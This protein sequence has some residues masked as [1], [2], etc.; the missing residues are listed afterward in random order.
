IFIQRLEEALKLYLPH[1]PP[2]GK[3][4]IIWI[5]PETEL[6][7]IANVG[8]CRLLSD[9]P[10][11]D[12]IR[13]YPTIIKSDEELA[14][15]FNS[16]PEQ[17]RGLIISAAFDE[18]SHLSG[19]IAEQ[20]LNQTE[21]DENT[22]AM[23]AENLQLLESNLAIVDAKNQNGVYP[24]GNWITQLHTIA[25][26]L[27]E[28][29]VER[30]NI[31]D[32]FIRQRGDTAEQLLTRHED[33]NFAL[34]IV[35]QE[36]KGFEGLLFDKISAIFSNLGIGVRLIGR[37][38]DSLLDKDALM[39]DIITQIRD[40][41]M[42]TKKQEPGSDADCK[43][44]LN[45]DHVSFNRA[46]E[47]IGSSDEHVAG[48]GIKLMQRLAKESPKELVYCLQKKLSII[49][50]VDAESR[51]RL[52]AHD[53]RTRE[54]AVELL[55]DLLNVRSN[56]L[57]ASLSIQEQV[58][59]LAGL[60]ASADIRKIS[61]IKSIVINI[62]K[63]CDILGEA[64]AS[65]IY[66]TKS[67]SVAGVFHVS[68]NKTNTTLWDLR[69]NRN[70]WVGA[71]GPQVSAE[72]ADEEREFREF[73]GK[74]LDG[75]TLRHTRIEERFAKNTILEFALSADSFS[76][77]LMRYAGNVISREDAIEYLVLAKRIELIFAAITQEIYGKLKERGIHYEFDYL[78]LY[79]D[80]GIEEAFGVVREFNRTKCEMELTMTVNLF[81]VKASPGMIAPCFFKAIIARAIGQLVFDSPCPQEL[82]DLNQATVLLSSQR[83]IDFNQYIDGLHFDFNNSVFTPLQC[84]A[85]IEAVADWFVYRIISPEE[86]QAFTEDVLSSSFAFFDSIQ[87]QNPWLNVNK[88]TLARFVAVAEFSGIRKSSSLLRVEWMLDKEARLFADKLKDFLKGLRFKSENAGQT[89]ADD[90][91]LSH[92]LAE[93]C[94]IKEMAD[95]LE[96]DVDYIARK[97]VEGG[98][99]LGDLDGTEMKLKKALRVICDKFD[100]SIIGAAVGIFEEGIDTIAIVFNNRHP[101]RTI[102]IKRQEAHKWHASRGADV[103]GNMPLYG[104]RALEDAMKL[105]T[106]ED[107]VAGLFS[108][109]N[110]EKG[111]SDRSKSGDASFGHFGFGGLAVNLGISNPAMAIGA[112]VAAAIA[113]LIIWSRR[114]A[115]IKFFRSLLRSAAPEEVLLLRRIERS[116]IKS[117]PVE[118]LDPIKRIGI[119]TGGGPATGHNEVICS[120]VEEAA[121][122][123]WEVVAIFQG[124]K[125]LVDDKLVGQARVLN[126]EEVQAQRHK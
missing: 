78:L 84:T 98:I 34:I 38:S 40:S 126:L 120:A 104:T 82:I 106:D 1:A 102:I 50:K 125:G 83:G 113:L 48:R 93:N 21:A 91:E 53:R 16:S 116:G 31:I 43:H 72:R 13:F 26:L 41:R 99:K 52:N 35:T 42:K 51:G 33:P 59:L 88:F 117:C 2:K 85:V 61:G 70:A 4:I 63:A 92:K 81:R 22:L 47:E 69:D 74:N 64:I 118:S 94:L 44:V 46:W 112:T 97:F 68:P 114:A 24:V 122:K 57:L 18:F 8:K 105:L 39:L 29:Q 115:I 32:S 71:V 76:N 60:S 30:Q 67:P 25:S 121:S 119:L 45:L 6:V 108:D 95:A 9:Y 86:F 10:E 49:V 20:G 89:V 66:L 65:K 17:A 111:P 100:G 54:R 12:I 28:L 7:E 96:V 90:I 80:Q 62:Q 55:K 37:L 15:R 79:Y 11:T 3:E 101:Y 123:G 27:E 87:E 107:K 19:V 75:I 5:T 109:S 124:W 77:V 103:P 14:R 110:R 36:I 58:R 73:L 23:L 56:C